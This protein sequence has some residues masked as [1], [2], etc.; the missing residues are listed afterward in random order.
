MTITDKP[1]KPGVT[2]AVAPADE[3]DK[4]E[5][6]Q[7]VEQQQ[8][9]QEADAKSPTT[10]VLEAAQPFQVEGGEGK[11]HQMQARHAKLAMGEAVADAKRHL[12]DAADVRPIL[13]KYPYVAVGGALAAGFVAAA[14]LVP[15]KKQRAA[16]RLRVLE[17]A[18]R[19][20]QAAAGK[21]FAAPSTGKGK[22]AL[23]LLWRFARPTLLSM[24]TGAIGGAAGGAGAA[25]N[26][27]AA[28]DAAVSDVT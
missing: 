3:A 20:E 21:K 19:T 6:Q 16:A 14:V 26:A 25:D 1:V 18:V 17:R 9:D 23:G 22:R 4:A 24:A 8:E 11:V 15:S 12:A 2:P 28:D 5:Q 10:A 27:P 7:D 13:R